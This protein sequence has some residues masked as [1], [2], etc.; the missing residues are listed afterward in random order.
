MPSVPNSG[1][2]APPPPP[3]WDARP[4]GQPTGYGGFWI[5]VVAYIL[6]GILLNIVFGIIASV[7]GISMLPGDPAKFDPAMFVSEM[8]SIQLVA[9]VGS[10]LYFAL[11][12][13]SARGATVGKM[14]VGLRVVDEQGNRISFLR[15]TGR[16]FGKFIS[17]IILF[18]GYLMV[19]FTDRKRGLH[20]II[21]GTLVVKIR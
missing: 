19:A 9:L 18:I 1:P 3:V 7:V 12:E 13:S 15:A 14:I 20:D 8:G 17:T 6:D 2:A 5:R 16:F 4:T 11:M 21:A 10:W